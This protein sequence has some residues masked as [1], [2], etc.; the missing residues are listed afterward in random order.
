MFPKISKDDIIT[1]ILASLLLGVAFS[2]QFEGPFGI[3]HWLAAFIGNSILVAFSLAT[4][5][6]AQKVRAKQYRANIKFKLFMPGGA[7]ALL[8]SLLTAGK[9]VYT[10]INTLTISPRTIA[11]KPRAIIALY[12]ILTSFTLVLLSKSTLSTITF[13]NELML[14]NTY[15]IIFNLVPSSTFLNKIYKKQFMLTEG[16]KI[17]KNDRN[18]WGITLTTSLLNLLVLWT[19][20]KVITSL[21]VVFLIS[22][23]AYGIYKTKFN[24]GIPPRKT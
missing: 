18:L 20:P 10:Q 22:L 3:S 23:A 6:Y 14:I 9:L 8:T 4:R 15:L 1:F 2:V 7:A 21:F 13:S 17:Y 19:I 16:D 12:G 5:L 24:N 11:K